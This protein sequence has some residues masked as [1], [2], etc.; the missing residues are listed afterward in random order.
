MVAAVSLAGMTVHLGIAPTVGV[1][2]H[3]PMLVNLV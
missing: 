1:G 2:V 3:F